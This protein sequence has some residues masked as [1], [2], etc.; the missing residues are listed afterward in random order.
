MPKLPLR[1]H[2]VESVDAIILKFSRELVAEES[3]AGDPGGR[4]LRAPGGGGGGNE[5]ARQGGGKVASRSRFR[6]LAH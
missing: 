5:A 3:T 2:E 1:V 6:L 4:R